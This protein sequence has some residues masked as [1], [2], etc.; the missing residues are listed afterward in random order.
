[1]SDFLKSVGGNVRLLRKK[2]GLTQE[3]LAERTGLQESYIG[4]I[5]R[6]ERNISLLS[7]EKVA[8]GLGVSPKTLLNFRGVDSLDTIE[9]N[10]LVKA[11]DTLLSDKESSELKFI[12]NFLHDLSIFVDSKEFK[13]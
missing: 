12:L 13:S 4:S 10:E 5:E 8:I 6:G 7:L 2:Q 11:I 9:Q 3:E 1:M